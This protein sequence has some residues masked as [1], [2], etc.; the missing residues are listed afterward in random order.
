MSHNNEYK[1]DKQQ[2]GQHT[3][4][5]H[6]GQYPDPTTGAVIP[7]IYTSSTYLQKSPGQHQGFEYSRSH[8][9]TRYAY[10]RAVAAMEN[11]SHGFAFASGMAATSTIIELLDSG[12]HIIAMDDLYGGTSRLFRMVRARSA[13]LEFSYVDLTVAADNLDQYLKDNSRMIWL[14]TPSNPMLKIVDIKK[15]CDFAKQHD[16]LV[17][18]DNTFA[19]PYLQQPLDLGADIIMHSATKFINGHSDMVGGMVVVN[20]P[21]LAQQM[22]FLQN[23]VGA[24]AGPFDSYQALRGFKTLPLRMDK[25]CTNAMH[26]AQW[27]EQDSRVTKVIY[28][29]LQS[30]PQHEL[31]K[32]QMSGF[33]GMMTILIKGGLVATRT[34]M[35]RCHLFALAESL[36]GIESLINHPAIMT[37]AAVP[38]EQRAQIGITDN[39]VRLSVGI[40]DVADLQADLDYA[41]G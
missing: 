9:P 36:G 1:K 4:A 11:G 27:L 41:L 3:K 2:F 30:H 20:E 24:V 21:E 40:E 19:S 23:S 22:A 15:I 33:G 37:H 38:A 18:V 32:Q 16:L 39:L 29:G 10:E 34:M 25:H 12:D 5:I 13:H 31:A 35:E 7:P 14:E 26:L 6:A 28:P 8:N 17:V